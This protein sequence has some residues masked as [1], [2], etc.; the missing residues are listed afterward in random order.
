MLCLF[1]PTARPGAAELNLLER[2]PA[3]RQLFHDRF[4]GGRPD[5]GF[6][7]FIPSGEKL[8]D[9]FFQILDAAERTPANTLARQLSEPAL[10]QIQPTGA[11]GHKMK[12]ETSMPLQPGA[13]LWLVVGAIV[14]HHQVQGNRAGK[15]FV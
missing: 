1:S 9:G 6:G 4:H 8:R 10:H 2:L 14:V 15:F 13:D 3:A 7:L 12:P 11:G 5:K